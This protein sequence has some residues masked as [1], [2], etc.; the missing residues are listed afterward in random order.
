MLNSEK[1]ETGSDVRNAGGR[2]KC[3][4]H[5]LRFGFWYFGGWGLKSKSHS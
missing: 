1:K 3:I 4:P 5:I 2:G